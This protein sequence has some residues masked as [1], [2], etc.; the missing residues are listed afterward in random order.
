VRGEEGKTSSVERLLAVSLAIFATGMA[1]AQDYPAR[2]L[3]L[4]VPWLPGGGADVIARVI[5]Q[6]VG[7][8]IGQQVIVDNCGGASTIIGMAMVAKAA[9]DGCTFGFPTSIRLA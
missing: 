5:F 7:D 3:R 1:F 9:P 4:I 2:A 6:K 8:A